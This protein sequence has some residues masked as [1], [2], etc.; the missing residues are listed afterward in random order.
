MC[1]NVLITHPTGWLC[2]HCARTRDALQVGRGDFSELP[3]GRRAPV[4]ARVLGSFVSPVLIQSEPIRIQAMNI[5]AAEASVRRAPKPMKILPISEVWSQVELPL[6]D[7][8][9]TAGGLA[10]GELAG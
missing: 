10:A 6:V 7:A 2:G 4:L 1:S 3:P 9:T 5:R 8:T